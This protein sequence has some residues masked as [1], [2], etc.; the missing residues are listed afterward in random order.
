MIQERN[1]LMQNCNSPRYIFL[2][3]FLVLHWPKKKS[4]KLFSLSKSNVQKSKNVCIY[5]FYRILKFCKY[6]QKIRNFLFLV[7]FFKKKLFSM[8]PQFSTEQRTFITLEYILR[9]KELEDLKLFLK[10]RPE[11]KIANFLI[12]I[13]Q[14]LCYSVIQS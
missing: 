9:R 13:L 14:I 2:N 5:Y 12:T 6:S 3:I 10:I 4:A 8:A 7:H 11:P 1:C